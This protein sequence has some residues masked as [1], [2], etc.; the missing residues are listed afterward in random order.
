MAIWI[1]RWRM[2]MLVTSQYQPRLSSITKIF[3]RRISQSDWNIQIKLNYTRLLHHFF[4]KRRRNLPWH[5]NYFSIYLL[6][7]SNS[8]W[9]IEWLLFNA[10]SAIFHLKIQMAFQ[11]NNSP[12]SEFFYKNKHLTVTHEYNFLGN[13]I[14]KGNFKRSIQELSKKWLKV[15]FVLKKIYVK[16]C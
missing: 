15:L 6:R 1:C 11:R 3:S 12:F 13:I 16:F 5:D 10:N 4:L 9:A 14:D 8:E 2:N 7:R